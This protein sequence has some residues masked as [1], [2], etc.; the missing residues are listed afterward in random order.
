MTRRMVWLMAASLLCL[1]GVAPTR[2]GDISGVVK[3]KDGS[4][5]AGVRVSG[6]TAGALGG[7][8]K[9]VYTDSKGKFTLSWKSKGGLAKL[10]ANGSTVA[11]DIRD[12]ENVVVRLK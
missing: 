7:S 11:T 10:Y 4:P 1:C 5:A 8:T 6:L 3:H 9:S 12:G 2:A